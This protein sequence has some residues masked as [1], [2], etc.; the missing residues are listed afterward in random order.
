MIKCIIILGMQFYVLHTRENLDDMSDNV[1]STSEE[2]FD[3][4]AVF[5]VYPLFLVTGIKHIIIL[6]ITNININLIDEIFKEFF[7]HYI[8][9][10]YK[11]I[12]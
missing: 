2:K 9:F 12:I 10:H 4:Q 6:V 3:F 1:K 11:K 7:T 5:V 8:N